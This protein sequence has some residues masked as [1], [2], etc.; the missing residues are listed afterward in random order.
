M[1]TKIKGICKG[2]FKYISHIFVVKEREMEIGYPT[3]VRHVAHIGC[4][5]PNG[6]APSW[7]NEFK[8]SDLAVAT[9]G[10]IGGSRNPTWSSQDFDQTLGQQ[11]SSSKLGNFTPTNLPS[12]PKKQK[13]KR[14]KIKS[15]SSSPKSGSSRSSRTSKSKSILGESEEADS[16]H[17]LN[18]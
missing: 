14:K 2:S 13:T 4:D 6:T 3:D 11:I 5:G 18:P 8:G 10:S 17:S 16:R 15:T 9:T 1:A 7:M 12:I